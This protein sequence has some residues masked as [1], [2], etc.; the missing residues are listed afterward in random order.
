MSEITVGLTKAQIEFVKLKCPFPLFCAGYGCVSGD[1][2]I[3]TINGLVPIDSITAPTLVLSYNQKHGQYQLSLSG[4]A[5]PKGIDYLYRVQTMHGE[6]VAS[7]HHRVLCA[8]GT[9][10]PVSE[11]KIGHVLHAGHAVPEDST[12]EH[13]LKGLQIDETHLSQTAVSYLGDYA[14]RA[15]Q[16][17]QQLLDAEACD[18]VSVP[19]LGDAPKWPQNGAHLGGHSQKLK[20]SRQV[21]SSYCKQKR[22][23]VDQL[24]LLEACVGDLAYSLHSAHILQSNRQARPLLSKYVHHRKA[25]LLSPSYINA[26]SL[27]SP[28]SDNI[29]INITREEVKRP[30][31]DMQVL[32]TNNYVCEGGFIHHNSGKSHVM[33][34]CAVTDAMHSPKATIS[35][36]EPDYNLIKTVAMPTI[37]YWLNFFKIKYKVNLQDHMITPE[38]DK[39]GKFIFKSMDNPDSLVGYESYRSHIDELDTLTEEKATKVWQKILGRN[40]QN[41]IGVPDEHKKWN[42]KSQRFECINRVSAYTTPEG[43]KFCYKMWHQNPNPDYQKVHGRTDENPTL[44][45]AYKQQLRDSYPSNLIEAYME[46]QFV[47]LTLGTVYHAYDRVRCGSRE[48]VV[49][50][51]HLYIGCDFNVGKMAAT[52]YV[53]RK[54]GTE[55]H[56]VSE[57]SGLKDTPDM[58]EAIRKNWYSKGHPITMYPDSSGAHRQASNASTSSIALLEQAG[59]EVRAKARNPAVVD[60]IQATNQAF[61][62]GKLFVNAELCKETARCFE[63]QAYDKNGNPDKG[64]NTDHQNDA[65]TYPI[66][67]EMSINKP[68]HQVEFKFISKSEF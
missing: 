18:Q 30:Y 60:R 61:S 13:Y 41:P 45:E 39:M 23:S 10:Q 32:D 27:D 35:I 16:Y 26:Q 46:G 50:K 21:V 14:T 68:L 55:W 48:E 59:F 67:Y 42:F 65:S 2:K 11:L 7:G 5:Y 38:S 4:G 12:L 24:G 34:F 51:E 52:V 15:R 37:E 40:R 49:E 28:S 22:H 31:Y 20:R 47:N 66:A 6:F 43:Y 64:G 33:G 57:L 58:I 62:T 25:M 56:A 53:K 44:S 29:I 36:Y 8:D 54:G 9:Y 17:G 3:Y 19:L 63:Q 1:T